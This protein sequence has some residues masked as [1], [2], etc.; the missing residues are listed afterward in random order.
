LTNAEWLS[1]KQIFTARQKSEKA[2][3]TNPKDKWVPRK[4]PKA[5]ETIIFKKTQ[6]TDGEIKL[7]IQTQF[8]CVLGRS[9]R[10]KEVQKY[11]SLTRGAISLG[12][13]TEGLRQMLKSVIL[14]SEFL[15]RLEFGVGPEDKHGRK[16]L[17]PH[18]AA[19]AIS[20]SLGD[21]GPDAA[22]LQAASDGK[23]LTKAD[24]KRE[25]T[26]LLA[27]KN[28]YK[29]LID[30]NVGG[31]NLRSHTSTHPKINRFF[32]EFFGYAF[33]GKVFKDNERSGGF[34]QN[35][36]RGTLGTAGRVIDEA[37]KMVDG[38][39]KQDKDVF[40]QL[41]TTDKYYVYDYDNKKGAATVAKWKA[42]Y[43]K[44]KDTDWLKNQ[45]SIVKENPRI[46]SLTTAKG[47]HTNRINRFMKHMSETFGKNRSPFPVVPW[48]HGNSYNHSQIYNFARLPSEPYK[49]KDYWGYPI[50]QPFKVANRKGILT[51]PSWLVAHSH[52]AETNPVVRGRWIREKLLAGRVPD[53]PIT[54]DAKVP[55]DPHKTLRERFD[56]VT[57]KAEC[58]KCHQH[59]NPLG[60][61]FEMFDDFGRYRTQENLEHEENIIAKAKHKNGAN[62][63]KTKAVNA[64]GALS[65]TENPRLDGNVTNA[66]D[67]IDRLAQSSRVRQS[68]I[69]HAFRFYM[70]RNEMLS[71]SQTLIDAD[72]AYVKNGGSFQA[73]IV[74]LLT[75]DS[76]IYRK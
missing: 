44:Y 50:K 70:G 19:Y 51:H 30:S 62:T 76:F 52:N 1:K 14:E 6:P 46:V 25:V 47:R 65:G 33:M 13:N 28:Y 48:A 68:I 54:V 63:Y 43:E 37:D 17:S 3:I 60:Y 22:L 75:S 31:K 56:D 49:E 12:G 38:I 42:F 55:E 4:T 73:V 9:A 71:D 8:D 40:V 34:Y 26:R 16:K 7:A 69:R 21:R 15:Y 64:K 61:P 45:A 39:L 27:D 2:K 23:L 36:G 59:M 32:R 72:K 53:V 57:Q 35:A 20:Y 11:L 41:L 29:G 58:W 67:M 18:E 10:T 74:S 5:F 66:L 24:Y